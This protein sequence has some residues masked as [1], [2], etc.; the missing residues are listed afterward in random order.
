[1]GV[2][3]KERASREQTDRVPLHTKER[4]GRICA[5]YQWSS[6]KKREPDHCCSGLD[7][8][9]GWPRDQITRQAWEKACSY[10]AE[11]VNIKELSITINVKVPMDVKPL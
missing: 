4:P 3:G 1:M 7:N 9:C 8:S 6:T 5:D 10:I 2:G 11:N